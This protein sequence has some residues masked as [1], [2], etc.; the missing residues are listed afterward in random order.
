M[1]C[2]SDKKV[3]NGGGGSDICSKR[4]RLL[5]GLREG[6]MIVIEERWYLSHLR[7]EGRLDLRCD[8][9]PSIP[10]EWLP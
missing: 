5:C 8:S 10:H 2:C 1:S 3:Q 6:E 4:T 9:Y 7:T